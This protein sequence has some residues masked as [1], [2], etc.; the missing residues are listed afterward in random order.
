MFKEFFSL[1]KESIIEHVK[2]RL[3]VVTV[4]FLVLFGILIYRLFDLQ[5]VNGEKY[6]ESFTYK[7]V[8]TVAVKATRGNIYDCN[9][10]LLAYNEASYTLSYISGTDL[11]EAA[12]AKETTSNELRNDIVYKT[13]LIL[14]QNGDKMS[15][16]LPLKLTS[17]GFEFTVSGNTLNTFLMNVYGASSVDSLTEEQASS[18]ADDIFKYM[19]GKDL[20]NISET[21]SDEAAL[22]ILAVRYEIWLNR[23]QQYMSVQLADGISEESYA[24]IK[25]NSDELLG[26]EVSVESH[27]VYNDSVYFAQIIGYIGNIS[28]EELEKYNET[29]DDSEKYS[30]NDMVG[31]MGL[32]SEFESYLRGK[33]GYQKMYVDNMGKVI[34]VIDSKDPVAGND[35]YLTIDSDLQKYCYNALETEIA[36]ILLAHI[37][38]VTTSTGKDDIP[39]ADVYFALFDNNVIS[40]DDLAAKDAS[41]LEQSVNSYFQSAKQNTLSRLDDILNVSHT[42]LHD[43]TLQYQD[44]MEFICEQL[45]EMGIYNPSKIDKSDAAY[46]SYI[47]N[48]ISLCEYLKYAISQGAIDISG[49]STK[50]DY[51]DTDE[52]YNVLT[53]YILKEFENNTSF[54]KLVFKYMI[55]SGELTG[56]QVINLLYDQGILN[57]ATDADYSDYKAGVMGSY[58]FICKKI[59]NLEITPAMLALDPCSGSI[60]VTNP[61]NGTVKAM[62]SYPSYDNNRLTN[63]IDAD[64]YSKITTDKTTPMYSRATMQQ[65][66]P[67]STFKMITAFA[68]MNEG[69]IGVND[70]IQTKGYFDKTETPAKCW[71]Y[72]S[73]HGTI[74]ISK[75]IEESCNYFFYELGY[76]MATKDTGTYSDITGVERL[77]KYAGM[78]GFDSTSGIELPESKPQI[79]DADS[80]RTAIGQGTN[81]FTATQL[82]RYVTTLANSGTCYDL[83]LVSEIKDIDGNVVYKNEHKVQNQLDFP[84]EQWNVVRQGMRQVVSVHTSSSALINQINVA[85]AGKTGTAQQSEARPNHALFV[86]FAPYENPEVTVTSVIPFGY[87]SGNAVELSGLVYAYLYDPDVLEN[88]TITGNNALSD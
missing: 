85:V 36:S 42:P 86:S 68:G 65:T 18:T 72:P 25:E 4:L 83:S 48:S 84:V 19:R 75:A 12:A 1:I 82:A 56:S 22:K 5:I 63:M 3:F 74:G 14:E 26:M 77:Q 60:V 76:R 27:R 70:V 78:F 71:I 52:I 64:Y 31:K 59:K 2:H 21:Y 17:K 61:N 57:M 13:I 34:E 23:Y 45:S 54:D 39:I 15:V 88:T 6:Q 53:E 73:A 62:T 16:S 32:E 55:I 29:L 11:T 41:E 28:N 35:I 38:N 24:A 47:N 67:G 46:V 30:A 58:D 33:D 66:A 20:F 37:K 49:I 81:N 44:Y 8:K 87:S 69:V 80:I 43:L 7:S 50:S 9:G 79:S 40:I 10:K 51:Y